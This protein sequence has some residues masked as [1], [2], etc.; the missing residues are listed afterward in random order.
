MEAVT[1]SQEHSAKLGN[2]DKTGL[3]QTETEHAAAPMSAEATHINSHGCFQLHCINAL[4]TSALHFDNMALKSCCGRCQLATAQI[5]V[6]FP[7]GSK[8]FVPPL[9]KLQIVTHF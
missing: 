9:K 5:E 6:C 7:K 4:I 3:Q 2:T 1:E 8:Y